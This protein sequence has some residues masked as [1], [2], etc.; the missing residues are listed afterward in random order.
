M[1]FHIVIFYEN[2][3]SKPE[4]FQLHIST[5]SQIPIQVFSLSHVAFPFSS[6][7]G[8]GFFESTHVSPV[9][10]Y[11]NSA[12]LT[13]ESP[14]YNN[15]YLFIFFAKWGC[16]IPPCIIL[17]VSRKLKINLSFSNKDLQT[18]Q[19]S[20]LVKVEFKAYNRL[21]PFPA[22]AVNIATFDISLNHLNEY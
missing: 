3:S 22:S 7:E 10:K 11:L 19:Y 16:G 20:N 18:F 6:A 14:L 4:K 17:I 5:N 15:Y 1:F 13:L 9:S 8:L 12:E 2:E 21:A